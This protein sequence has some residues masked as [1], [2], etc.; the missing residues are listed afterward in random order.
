MFPY[1]NFFNK[2]FAGS[3]KSNIQKQAIINN[4]G[5]INLIFEKINERF[6]LIKPQLKNYSDRQG[7]MSQ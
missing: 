1:L 5:H 6:I 7:Q 2:N 4:S 3:F